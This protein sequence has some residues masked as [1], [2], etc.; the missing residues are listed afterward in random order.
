MWKDRS[1]TLREQHI[2]LVLTLI[3][4]ALV[5]LIVSAFILLTEHIGS[6]MYPLEGAAW[7]RFVVPIIGALV[8]GYLMARF[9][10][11]ARGSGIPQTK[12][13]MILRDGRITLWTVFGRFL[14]STA[15]LASGIALGREGPSV[16]I[17]AG[18]ASE[19]GRKCGFGPSKLRRL[20]PLGSA[21]AI[22]AAFN[23]PIAA[24]LFALEEVVGD[25]HAPV[26]GS[27]VL[28]SATSWVVL[29][30]LLGDEPLFHVPSYQLV[31][32][33][34]FAIYAVLGI[35]GGFASVAFV[36]LTLLIRGRFL[37]LPK[38]TVWAHPMAGG[39]LVGVLALWVPQVIGVGYDY[40]GQVLNNEITL[41]I[42]L[43]LI[44]LKIIASA[45]CYGSGNTGGIFGPSL[46]MGAMVGGAVGSIA[47]QFLPAYTATPG[48]YALVGMGALFAGI[49][50]T[51]LTSVF[52][53]F[54]ITRDY[55]IVVPVMIANLIS[56]AISYRL[57]R[58]PV[59]EALTEQEGIH[60]PKEERGRKGTWRTVAQVMRRQPCMIS[61]DANVAELPPDPPGGVYVV[62]R[63]GEY[64]T[65]LPRGAIPQRDRADSL[66][67]ADIMPPKPPAHVHGDQ[68]IERVLERMGEFG[69]DVLP[70]VDRADAKRVRGVVTLT[71]IMGH[72]GVRRGS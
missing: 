11:D 19:L 16:Q 45:A 61:P 8:T 71:D 13:A 43:L 69:V 72:Y 46:F 29:H 1:L 17:G 35:A 12:V 26:L 30:S 7:R 25:L 3:V 63:N 31:H 21:A 28:A 22:A 41:T 52:M 27:A 54:E 59:Y 44:P 40:V 5:G 36:K 18:V 47:H 9:F 68:S 33:I 23:T 67:V 57:Q 42:V 66:H 70:V 34:E 32:P 58:T 60:L 15:S 55:S 53:I 37:K 48:A 20:I 65:L 56:F 38:S 51:P 62:T 4:G 24:V 50:R 64:L 14:C 49:I 10:P 2:F 39:I 6:R